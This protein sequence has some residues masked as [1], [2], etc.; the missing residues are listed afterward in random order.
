LK[1]IEA[2]NVYCS[3]KRGTKYYNYYATK[4]AV[5]EVTLQTCYQTKKTNCNLQTCL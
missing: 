1:I 4:E 5:A 2:V 3:V